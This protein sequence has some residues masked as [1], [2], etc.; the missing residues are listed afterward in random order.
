MDDGKKGGDIDLLVLA[1]RVLDWKEKGEI[2]N[3]FWNI[4][5]MQKLELVSF[6]HKEEAPFKKVALLNAI[7]L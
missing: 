7:L 4:F 6:T 1:D 5:G 3:A 2:K